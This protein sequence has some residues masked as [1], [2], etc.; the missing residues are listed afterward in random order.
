MFHLR[1]R[2]P[3]R[4]PP[5]PATT[6]LSHSAPARRADHHRL[7]LGMSYTLRRFSRA[8][9]TKGVRRNARRR[10]L[11][12]SVEVVAGTLFLFV[13]CFFARWILLRFASIEAC[14]LF[15]RGLSA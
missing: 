4:A 2:P 7:P 5:P 6:H 1:P 14:V 15:A 8:P 10:R 3:W 13:G 9:S 11:R 12:Y